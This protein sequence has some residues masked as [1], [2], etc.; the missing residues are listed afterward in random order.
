MRKWLVAVSAAILAAAARGQIRVPDSE[1]VLTLASGEEIRGTVVAVGLKAVLVI[2]DDKERTF[3]R[4]QVERITRG[5]VSPNVK[6]YATET[7]EGVLVVT[8]PDT[9]EG[10]GEGEG[11]ATEA[12]AKEERPKPTRVAKKGGKGGKDKA[13]GR[14]KGPPGITNERIQEAMKNNPELRNIV[15][16]IGGP[17]KAREW[18]RNNRGNPEIA[19][20]LEQLMKSGRL[21]RG[22]PLGGGRRR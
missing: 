5:E 13:K 11:A 12:L 17:D 21:P 8:G 9:G 10:E 7:V 19:K 6:A 3:P 20:M 14:G 16:G 1:D 4:E 18:V 15:K 22:L 2:V